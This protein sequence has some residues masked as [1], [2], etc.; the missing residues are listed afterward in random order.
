MKTVQV[1]T[2][3]SNK[4][5]VSSEVTSNGDVMI[6]VAESNGYSVIYKVNPDY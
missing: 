1:T 6:L 3:V 5:I 2:L 4:D